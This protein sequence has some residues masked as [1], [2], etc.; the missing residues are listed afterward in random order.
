MRTR[1]TRFHPS[2]TMPGFWC[3]VLGVLFFFCSAAITNQHQL[4][5]LEQHKRAVESLQHL[6]PGSLPPLSSVP[7]GRPARSAV[8]ARLSAGRSAALVEAPGQRGAPGRAPVPRLGPQPSGTAPLPP[9]QPAF[10]PVGGEPRLPR[11]PARPA[12]HRGQ[13]PSSG[14]F[15]LPTLTHPACAG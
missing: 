4:S 12:A 10:R 14:S 5:S 13:H 11:S 15:R 6:G 3:L 1:L 7:R 2:R 9:H 8:S